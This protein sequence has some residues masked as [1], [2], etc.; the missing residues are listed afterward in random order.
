MKKVLLFGGMLLL[1]GLFSACSGDDEVV[2]TDHG[3]DYGM[4]K[5]EN[6]DS[7]YQVNYYRQN[8]S[9]NV[10]QGYWTPKGFIELY[11]QSTP[12][13]NLLVRWSDEQGK[14]AIDY[15]LE[16]NQDVMTKDT[17]IETSNEYRIT[18]NIYFES[19]HFYV[20]SYYKSSEFPDIDR[21]K[22]V[23]LPQIM[24]KMKEGE[25]VEAIIRDYAGVLT[26]SE[27]L[28]E[29]LD[30]NIYLFDCNL[31]TSREVLELNAEIY[32]RNDV[33]YSDFNTYYDYDF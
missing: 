12:P 31:K 3:N 10:R 2:G 26:F 1:L 27:L 16:K 18:S 33:E 5:T 30:L 4:W 32:Q 21:Y 11:P 25:S 22:L 17:Y 29:S 9:L 24:L 15:I 14:K 23:V 8:P 6:Y 7:M 19:P 13:Y 28:G 20:S